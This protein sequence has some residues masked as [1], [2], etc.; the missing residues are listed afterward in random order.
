MGMIGHQ[1]SESAPRWTPQLLFQRPNSR[2][3]MTICHRNLILNVKT[4]V[5]SSGWINP[6]SQIKSKSTSLTVISFSVTWMLF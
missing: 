5:R 2:C 6:W 4:E 3:S 1:D